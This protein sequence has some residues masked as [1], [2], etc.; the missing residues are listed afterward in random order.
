MQDLERGLVGVSISLEKRMRTVRQG[1]P[2]WAKEC[3]RHLQLD[4]FRT[5]PGHAND[6]TTSS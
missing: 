6:T 4:L 2:F 5:R 3:M 1:L